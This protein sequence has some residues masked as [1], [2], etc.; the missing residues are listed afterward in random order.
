MIIKSFFCFFDNLDSDYFKNI[1]KL[2]FLGT[3]FK[4]E[5]H[6]TKDSV[7][8]CYISFYCFDGCCAYYNLDKKKRVYNY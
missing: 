5:E 3:K 7:E 8:T 4:Y 6:C 1:P 2:S